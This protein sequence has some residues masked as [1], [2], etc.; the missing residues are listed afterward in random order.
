MHNQIL[1][2]QALYSHELI[3]AHVLLL[4]GK[5]EATEVCATLTKMLSES[6]LNVVS[7]VQTLSHCGLNRL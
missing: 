3:A 5:T 1:Q 7:K 6:A 2:H 4:K